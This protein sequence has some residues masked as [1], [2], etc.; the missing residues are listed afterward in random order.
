MHSS[1]KCVHLCVQLEQLQEAAHIG[2]TW[3]GDSAG[4]GGPWKMVPWASEA[5]G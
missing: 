1:Q 3:L 5:Q 2:V 4:A